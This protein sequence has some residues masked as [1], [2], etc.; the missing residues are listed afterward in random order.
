MKLWQKL[1]VVLI[2]P[3][4]LILN[5]AIYLL[6]GITYKENIAAEK[7]Q[8]VGDFGMIIDQIYG[9]MQQSQLND[10]D[11]K[12]IIQKYTNYYKQRKKRRFIIRIRLILILKKT[13]LKTIRL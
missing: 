12:N 7:K 6:F 8:A 13:A 2:I 4:L 10:R 9:E 5:I 1:Y 11:V 3:I